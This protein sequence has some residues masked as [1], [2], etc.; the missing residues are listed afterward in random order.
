MNETARQIRRLRREIVRARWDVR[1]SREEARVDSLTGIGNRRAWA[2]E[3]ES[4][5]AAGEAFSIVLFDLANLKAANEAL[6]H[7]GA[8]GLLADVGATIRGEDRIAVRQGGDE[9][10][11]FLSTSSREDARSVRDRL[12]SDFGIR[13]VGFG[14]S[15]FLVGEVVTWAPG[16]GSIEAEL[17]E[18]DF[19]L[20]DRKRRMKL[21]RDQPATRAEAL[22]RISGSV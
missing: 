15:V 8:D 11:I 4:R 21:K 14:L 6:G 16:S 10:A 19:A 12:E 1:L 5:T 18:A 20:E 22:A 17:A 9:F 13:S 3:I 7:V 2:E